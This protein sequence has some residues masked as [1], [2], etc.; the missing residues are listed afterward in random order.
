MQRVLVVDDNCDAAESL[1][2]LLEMEGFKVSVAYDGV[3]ALAA[4]ES[5]EPDIALLDIGMPGM[6]GYELARR[7]RATPRGRNL[8]LVALT[9]WGQAEDKKRSADAGFDEHLT[10][11]VDPEMLSRVIH[12]RRSVAA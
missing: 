1:G 8:V 10:K 7:I 11:P 2:M 6:D 5:F 4:L 12:Q 3:G 9:G